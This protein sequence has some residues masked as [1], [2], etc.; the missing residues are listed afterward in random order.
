MSGAGRRGRTRSRRPAGPF[1]RRVLGEDR[2]LEPLQLVTRDEPELVD[3]GRA[4]APVGLERVGL[5]PRAVEREHELSVQ[6][7]AV[8]VLGRQRLELPDDRGMT[9]ERRSTASRSSSASSRSSASRSGSL[10]AGPS[11]GASASGGPRNS[12]SAARR[13]RAAASSSPA[14]R[15]RRA[16]STS[17]SKR[18]RSRS[19]GSSATAY[20][21]ARVTIGS[22]AP[23]ARR[24]RDTWTCSAL[25]AVAGGSSPHSTSTRRDGETASSR[26]ASSSAASSERCLAALR[27]TGP[28]GPSTRSG[29]RIANCIP[30][31]YPRV[32]ARSAGPRTMAA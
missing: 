15:A 17:G 20:P 25:A 14:A 24:S 29:P 4:H 23:S 6:L 7:L 9:A 26:W 16:A 12:A 2:R 13:S 32:T 3:Q 21:D 1:E 30:S 27:T 31:G 11:S 18:A 5:P 28:S 22:P 19:P 8:R 10:A